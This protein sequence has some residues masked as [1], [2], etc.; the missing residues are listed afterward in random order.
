MKIDFDLKKIFKKKQK[1]RKG[2]FH[3]N[4]NIGWELIV[5]LAFI[6]AMGFLAHGS[7]L[8]IETNREFDAPSLSDAVGKTVLEKERMDTALEYFAER[9]RKAAGIIAAPARVV[10]PSR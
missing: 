3:T 4:P 10:D 2:G 7:Y 8:F 6:V 9:E 5:G 1:F